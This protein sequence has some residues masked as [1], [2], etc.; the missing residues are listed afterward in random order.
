MMVAIHHGMWWW[1]GM[2]HRIWTGFNLL[3]TIHLTIPVYV[4]SVY[5]RTGFRLRFIT[6]SIITVYNRRLAIILAIA[7]THK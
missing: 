7:W 1:I 2:I 3:Y 5:V 4:S 6:F